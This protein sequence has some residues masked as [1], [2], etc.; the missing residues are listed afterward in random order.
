MTDKDEILRLR[1]ENERLEKEAYWLAEALEERSNC[2]GCSHE[3]EKC[4]IGCCARHWREAA[5]KAVAEED[6]L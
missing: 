5:R 1:A 3:D 2:N 4:E 6:K